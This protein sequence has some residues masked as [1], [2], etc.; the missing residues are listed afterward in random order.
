MKISVGYVEKDNKGVMCY[1]KEDMFGVVLVIKEKRENEG[2]CDRERV[3]GKM[4]DVRVE[5]EGSY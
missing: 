2:M 1:G 4:V 5:D 3:V